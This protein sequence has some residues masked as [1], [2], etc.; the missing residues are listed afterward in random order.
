MTC[1]GTVPE[2]VKRLQLVLDLLSTVDSVKC[3]SCYW[4]A[5]QWT[6]TGTNHEASNDV[7]CYPGLKNKRT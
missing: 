5:R 6:A 3:N 4:D 1:T 2:C 7:N